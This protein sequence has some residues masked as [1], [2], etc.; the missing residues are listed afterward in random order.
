MLL[1]QANGR[2]SGD[3]CGNS[4]HMANTTLHLTTQMAT[5]RLASYIKLHG[6]TPQNTLIVVITIRISN[7]IRLP[8]RRREPGQLSRY[9]LRAGRS[10]G[11]GSSP[12]TGN[13][14]FLST[15]SR[16]VLMPTQHPIQWVL[17]ALPPGV[18]RPRHDADHS[19]PTIA[20]VRNM[21]IY[22]ST[23]PYVRMACCLIK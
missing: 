7:F 21:W 15:S 5:K 17:G 11:R 23:P 9:W 1:F 16:P 3:S 13:I 18:K 2:E 14:S 8:L 19:L 20:K 4:L 12:S 10:T 22:T 6:V